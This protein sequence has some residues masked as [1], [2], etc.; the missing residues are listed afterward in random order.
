MGNIDFPEFLICN[1]FLHVNAE[2][3]RTDSFVFGGTMIQ[4][5]PHIQR[6]PIPQQTATFMG[7]AAA[8][9]LQS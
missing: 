9:Q 8:F 5:Q 1:S 7:R 6:Q 3:A 2:V 4:E